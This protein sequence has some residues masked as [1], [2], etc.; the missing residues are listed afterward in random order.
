M[1]LYEVATVHLRRRFVRLTKIAGSWCMS[2]RTGPLR[3]ERSLRDRYTGN[4][5]FVGPP[6]SRDDR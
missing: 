2:C 6:I 4:T 1:P 3:V 5:I